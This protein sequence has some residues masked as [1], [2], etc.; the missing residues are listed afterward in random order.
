[1]NIFYVIQTTVHIGLSVMSRSETYFSNPTK[2]DPTRWLR[3]ADNNQSCIDPFASLPFSHGK[4][5]CIGRR[6]A[7]QKIYVI[8]MKVRS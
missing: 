6:M 2:F 1:M 5:M 8:I 7:E 3:T 4:R